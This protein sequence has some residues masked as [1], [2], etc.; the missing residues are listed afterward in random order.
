MTSTEP[1]LANRDVVGT[2]LRRSDVA[3]QVVSK[4]HVGAGHG[5]DVHDLGQVL[6]G[7]D[8][9]GVDVG[10]AQGQLRCAQVRTAA[11]VQA[12]GNGGHGFAVEFNAGG[13]VFDHQSFHVGAPNKMSVELVV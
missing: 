10:Q 7:D 8:G 1:G 9:R 2:E 5:V 4:G 12:T 6:A 3:L 11:Q 13:K